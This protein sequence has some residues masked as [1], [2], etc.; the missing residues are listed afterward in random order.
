MTGYFFKVCNCQRVTN[1][2]RHQQ[3]FDNSTG[4]MRSATTTASQ[5]VKLTACKVLT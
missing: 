2:L 5:A 4:L 1:G 3:L